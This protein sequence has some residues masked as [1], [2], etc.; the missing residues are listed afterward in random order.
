GM[1]KAQVRAR[2]G[3]PVNISSSSSS[4]GEVWTYMFNNFDGRI[5]IPYYGLAHHALRQRHSGVIQFNAA[6]RVSEFQWNESNPV[7]ATI[8]R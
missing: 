1:T 8:F 3:T 5:F 7:G 2:Y 4:R 6:G